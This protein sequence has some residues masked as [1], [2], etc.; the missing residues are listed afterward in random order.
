MVDTEY[1]ILIVSGSLPKKQINNLEQQPV[2][3]SIPRNLESK[4]AVQNY[5]G[6]SDWRLTIEQVQTNTGLNP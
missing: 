3:R 6:N 5:F 4:R 1:Y 2:S